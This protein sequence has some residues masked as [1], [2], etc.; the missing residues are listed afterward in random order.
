METPEHQ[1]WRS[2]Q[3]VNWTAVA[4]SGLGMGLLLFIFAG[5]TPWTGASGLNQ[6]MGRPLPWPWPT[7]LLAHFALA[8][9]YMGVIAAAIYR[10]RVF[11]AILTGVVVALFLY[12]INFVIF[13]GLGSGMGDRGD[14]RA[15][16]AHLTLGLLGSALY[17]AL[18]VPP[19]EPEEAH[20]S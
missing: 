19:P 4:K 18:S 14:A 2:R 3:Q 8:W 6:V 12:G 16:A 20:T 7:L 10:L 1:E 5:G 13:A 15:L 17:K 11:S 9:L